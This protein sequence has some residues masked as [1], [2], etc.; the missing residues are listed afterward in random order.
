MIRHPEV[1]TMDESAKEGAGEREPQ[2]PDAA[3]A[4]ANKAAASTPAE[5]QPHQMAGTA[6]NSKAD[7][8]RLPVVWSP[9]LDAGDD[10]AAEPAQPE[11]DDEPWSFAHG[12]EHEAMKDEQ[13]A[14]A[15]SANSS[16]LLRFALLAASVAIAA[17]AGSFAGTHWMVGAG[18]AVAAKSE[19]A[20]ANTL[21][22]LKAQLAELNALKASVDTSTR[23]ANSQIGKLADRLDRLEHAQAEPVAKLAHIADAVDRLE[24]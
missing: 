10:I 8:D 22:A 6:D 3:K 15:P 23:G 11:A 2:Q 12:F 14:T 18:H 9:K 19:T 4:P 17:A 5:A 13:A 21:Q 16:R 1:L 20:D 24:K 7:D